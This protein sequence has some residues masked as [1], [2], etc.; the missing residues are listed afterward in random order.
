MFPFNPDRVLK[1]TPKPPA[2]STVMRADKIQVGSCY[3]DKVPQTPKT[4]VSVEGLTSLQ[5]LIKQD[6][7]TLNRTS[8][9]RLE[10]HIQKLANAAQIS[11]AER[12]LLHDQNQILTRINNE[13]KVR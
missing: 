12:A 13:A 8:I 4:L 10:R 6:T 1:V 3:Q 5:N 9:Q 7:H 11:F 2:Q